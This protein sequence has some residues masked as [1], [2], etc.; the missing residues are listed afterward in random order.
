MSRHEARLGLFEGD[1]V[2]Y[3]FA[4][5]RW[6]AS[7]RPVAFEKLVE[8][9]RAIDPKH[10]QRLLFADAPL[11]HPRFHDLVRECRSLGLGHFAL[12][13]DA[14]PLAVDGAIDALVEHGFEKLFVVVGGVRAKIHEA[15][16]ADP[17]GFAAAMEG[18]RRATASSLGAYVV[19]P[20]L[21]W[22]KLDV[23]PMLEALISPTPR[24]KG[25][26]LA[27]PE[28]RNV[29]RAAHRVLLPYSAQAKLAE[30]VFDACRRAG[31]EYGFTLR[32]GVLPCA[33]GGALDRF[34]TVFFDR[35]NFLQH[36]KT[37]ERFVRVAACAT[38]SLEQSCPG[39]EEA[40][41]ATFGDAETRPLPLEVSMDWNLKRMNRLEQRDFKNVSDFDN[42]VAEKGRALLRINGHCNMSCAFC[43]VDRT[44]P[45]FDADALKAEISRM[46]RKN[47]THL[48]L[49]GGEPTLHPGLADLVRHAKAEGFETIEIQT[50]G[51]KTADAEYARALVEAGLNKATLSLHSIDPEHS[52]KITRLAGAF[53][54]TI[55]GMR[56]LRR[57][58]VLTQ[59]AHV[60]TKAN[61][62][63]L[64]RT[65]RFL[66]E[67]FPEDEGHLSVCFGVAQPISDLVYTWVMP[68]FDEIAP[69]MRDAL[70]YCLDTKVGFGGMIGQG[71]YPPCMLGGDMRYYEQNLENIYRS[72]DF[73]EQFYKAP[74]CAECS[75]DP[76]CMGVRKL[77]VETYGDAE[78]VPFRADI[79]AIKPSELAPL[80]GDRS[81]LVQLRVRH[82]DP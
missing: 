74:R 69:F 56:N 80:P 82:E 16:M 57:L 24:I 55:E 42:D 12:E 9:A 41:F 5:P 67:Q 60:V 68:R 43:F 72:A 81:K 66:R 76:Y 39:V 47:P 4:N 30:R 45:D 21:E 23:E 40:Y 31:V 25:F 27:L 2:D 1:R 7:R 59:V 17:G 46:A 49:S 64:P 61:Y 19:M 10:L 37:G 35:M 38:C 26:L 13:T 15:V 51:V 29:P 62:E 18:L 58:G 44:V 75:F 20:V 79:A 50:N 8:E 77:Y 71:G 36:A 33:A 34:G 22:T 70:D 11:D 3:R 6:K 54:K 53:E 65:V 63:E 14:A 28:M 78:L 52:D 73:D 32:R 48:V